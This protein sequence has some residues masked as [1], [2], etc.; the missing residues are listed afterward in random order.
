[1]QAGARKVYAIEAS[2]MATFAQ[3][4]FESNGEVGARVQVL[5][6]KVE[7]L[8]DTLP[9]KA[10]VLISEP[11]GTLLVNER[12][13]ETYILARKHFM[14]PGGLMFPSIGRIFLAAFSDPVLYSELQ[15]MASFWLNTSFYGVNLSCLHGE[16]LEVCSFLVSRKFSGVKMLKVHDISDISHA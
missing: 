6:G 15:S 1:V 9:E 7:A 16:A 11:M 5:H 14:K 13:L 12:M 10:D 3:K 2:K 4:L 8:L